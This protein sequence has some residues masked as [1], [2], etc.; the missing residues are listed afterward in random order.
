MTSS[1]ST[2]RPAPA[3]RGAGPHEAAAPPAT[4]DATAG[5]NPRPK[6]K[7]KAGRPAGQPKPIAAGGANKSIISV[8]KIR[9]FRTNRFLFWQ[10]CAV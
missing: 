3:R 1:S 4:A 10:I 6:A 9:S 2:S 7:A 5:P 8:G